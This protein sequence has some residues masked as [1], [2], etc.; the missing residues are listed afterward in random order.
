M[1]R[2][3]KHNSF[4]DAKGGFMYT[5]YWGLNQQSQLSKFHVS[6][7]PNFQF[8]LMGV[9]QWCSKERAISILERYEKLPLVRFKSFHGPSVPGH[10]SGGIALGSFMVDGM[11]LIKVR[12]SRQVYPPVT[13]KVDID[14]YRK[15]HPRLTLYAPV[16]H[17]IPM[18]ESAIP[19]LMN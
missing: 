1:I 14:Y 15:M 16:E 8:R 17:L 13:F 18:T 4:Y 11:K 5:I 6:N 12:M 2:L 7:T 19:I 3:Q 9:I 10:G